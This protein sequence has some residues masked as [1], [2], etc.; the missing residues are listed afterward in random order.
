MLLLTGIALLCT[1]AQATPAV[2]SQTARTRATT[3]L[4]TAL[5]E[6]RVERETPVGLASL[7]RAGLAASEQLGDSVLGRSLSA[8]TRDARWRGLLDPRA[9][10][11]QLAR[12]LTSVVTDLEFEP[13]IEA[14]LPVGFPEPTPV[15]EIELKRFPVYRMVRADMSGRGSGR[16]FWKLF[17]HIQKSDIAMTAPVE[18]EWSGT[19]GATRESSMAFLYGSPQLGATGPDGSLEV[20]DTE[21]TWAVSLGCRGD[22]T[23]ETIQAARQELE[24][25]IAARADLLVI[26]DLRTMGYNSPMVPRDRRYFEVQLPVQPMEAK[27]QRQVVV[28]FTDPREAQRWRAVDDRV[29]G[30]ISLSDLEYSGQGSSS[31]AGELSLERNGGFASVRAALPERSLEGARALLLRVRGD[32]KAYK[33]RLRS[34][35]DPD[36]VHHEARFQTEAGVETEYSFALSDFAAVWRGRSV[37]DAEPLDP[38]AIR[39]LGLMISDGQAGQFRL[40]VFTLAML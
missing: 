25:W 37:P 11:R 3:T 32:G 19:A 9:A 13:L 8:D 6:D 38:A 21:P 10:R 39:S 34:A 15:G 29:M 5:A 2:T 26:G 40:E 33:L 35:E 30:G 7:L 1:A 24:R 4:R 12:D 23:R 17:T 27:A 18:M 16:A 14:E 28:D 20:L 36:G 22:A 31:F